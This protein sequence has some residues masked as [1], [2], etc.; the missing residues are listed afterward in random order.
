[1]SNT[2]QMKK[3]IKPTHK[4]PNY[5]IMFHFS[6]YI[7]KNCNLSRIKQVSAFPHIRYPWWSHCMSGETCTH[8]TTGNQMT[9]GKDM[10]WIK[11]K[12]LQQFLLSRHYMYF[13]SSPPASLLSLMCFKNKRLPL[14]NYLLLLIIL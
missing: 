5:S 7:S 8:S 9:W 3:H 13:L 6:F 4:L 14:K 1:M 12:Y 11:I 10:K 2:S